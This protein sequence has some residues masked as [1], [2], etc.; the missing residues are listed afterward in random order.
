VSNLTSFSDSGPPELP[1]SHSLMVADSCPLPPLEGALKN[2]TVSETILLA[3]AR[4]VFG[5]H[6]LFSTSI[7]FFFSFFRLSYM[8]LRCPPPVLFGVNRF[9]PLFYLFPLSTHTH[10]CLRFRKCFPVVGLSVFFS[11]FS[12]PFHIFDSFVFR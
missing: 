11:L 7:F 9:R 5:F 4:V 1:N 6:D 12:F 10:L 8:I 3:P 2:S